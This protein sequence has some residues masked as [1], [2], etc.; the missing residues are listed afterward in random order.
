MDWY[1]VVPKS[2]PGLFE[3]VRA[4]TVRTSLSIRDQPLEGPRYFDDCVGKPPKTA[5]ETTIFGGKFTGPQILAVT[6]PLCGRG[7]AKASWR[8]SGES[9]A[10]VV[11]ATQQLKALYFDP[12]FPALSGL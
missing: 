2:L 1:K 9:G 7:R 5:S 11:K 12:P 3:P 4:H 10:A 6:V 8:S